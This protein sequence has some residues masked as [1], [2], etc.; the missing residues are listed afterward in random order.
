VP[1]PSAA[2]LAVLRQLQAT[3]EPADTDRGSAA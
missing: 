3:L 1:P 2:E